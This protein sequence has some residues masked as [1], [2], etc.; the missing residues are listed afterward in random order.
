MSQE[1]LETE[2]IEP[3]TDTIAEDVDAKEE[4][5]A[6]KPKLDSGKFTI[7]FEATSELKN[8]DKDKI[9][10]GTF[11]YPSKVTFEWLEGQTPVLSEEAFGSTIYHHNPSLFMEEQTAKGQW[12]QE[13]E[14]SGNKIGISKARYGAE[15]EL[16]GDAAIEMIRRRGGNGTTI[17][18]PL[19]RSCIW[20]TMRPATEQELA[21]LDYRLS[22]DENAVGR[23][24]AGV[25]LNAG[26]GSFNE[27]L[28]DL[29]LSLVVDTNVSNRAGGI[30][31]SLRERID[32][33]DYTDLISGMLIS[34]YPDGYPWE[35]TCANPKCGHVVT[36]Q[37]VNF[38]RM[39]WHD[40]SQ[41]T[42]NQLS[43]LIKHRKAITDEEIKAYKDGFKLTD[44]D[45][46]YLKHADLNIHFK[47][48]NMAEYLTSSKSWIG[49]IENKYTTSLTKYTTEQQRATFINTQVQIHRFGKYLHFIDKITFPE[50]DSEIV[51]RDTIAKALSAIDS[52]TSDFVDF[53]EAVLKYIEAHSL[54]IFGYPSQP[55][56]KC[57]EEPETASGKFS[58]IVPVSPDRT[59]FT[60]AQ[61]KTLAMSQLGAE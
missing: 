56:L 59:F 29:A 50:S 27:A 33:L 37:R 16:V 14:F 17:R 49:N 28:V 34:L 45:F 4:H 11:N 23:S 26:S 9:P 52:T 51:D 10:L 5:V 7:K 40:K 20:V 1:V 24:T 18:I 57:N 3:V 21:D 8:K 15:G 61:L 39:L 12:E 30:E 19:L 35:F 22:S 53:E 48:A 36:D 41:L 32:L 42:E 46:V 47:T 43:A 25:L 6:F 31:K 13:L 55:C 38:V 60:L 54:S 58:S 44:K 2:V